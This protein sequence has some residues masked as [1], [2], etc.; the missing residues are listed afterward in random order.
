MSK[1]TRN[2]RVIRTGLPPSPEEVLAGMSAAGGWNAAQ[3]A[4]W[5]IAW[6]PI[7]GWRAKLERD[8]R[9]SREADIYDAREPIERDDEAVWLG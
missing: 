4:Y 3:L 6:P 7:H 2:T 9:E 5:G 1:K 8:Y